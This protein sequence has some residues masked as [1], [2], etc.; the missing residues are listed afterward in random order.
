MPDGSYLWNTDTSVSLWP[1]A[2][3]APDCEPHLGR[4]EPDRP[5]QTQIPIGVRRIARQQLAHPCHGVDW[6]G[7]G[8][9]AD[10][11]DRQARLAQGHPV[12]GLPCAIRAFHRDR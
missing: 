8:W 4:A 3:I 1:R 5:D 2:L 9:P 7:H 10:D 11:Q 6:D 12:L